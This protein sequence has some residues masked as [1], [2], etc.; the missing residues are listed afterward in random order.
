M[1]GFQNVS[2]L[3]TIYGHDGAI[4]LTSS[5]T[6]KIIMRADEAETAKWCSELLGSHEIERLNM[7]ALAGMSSYRE[8]LNLSPHRSTDQI[9]TPGQIQLLKPFE[10]YLC[11]AGH[12][13]TMIRIPEQHLNAKYP[14][15]ISRD[16]N[17]GNTAVVDAAKQSA[18]NQFSSWDEA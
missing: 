17:R 6:T 7:T 12:N 3:C 4:T 1:I 16:K 10:G 9:V 2:Q 18:N 11:V 14:A 15:F 5:P 13:R 8:G